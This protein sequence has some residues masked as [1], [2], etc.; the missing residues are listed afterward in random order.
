MNIK[1][2]E[3]TLK[4]GHGHEQKNICCVTE[5]LYDMWE[6]FYELTMTTEKETE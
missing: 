3:L 4:V 5:K 1:N 6:T 2:L